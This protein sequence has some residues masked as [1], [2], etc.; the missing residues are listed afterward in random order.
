MCMLQKDDWLPLMCNT[1]VVQQGYDIWMENSQIILY[2]I[3]KRILCELTVTPKLSLTVLST[4]SESTCHIKVNLDAIIINIDFGWLIIKID[5]RNQQ[6]QE[7][8]HVYKYKH[9]IKFSSVQFS[10]CFL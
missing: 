10:I 4:P 6:R 2:Y 7:I 3:V 1:A 9:Q 8:V 5:F